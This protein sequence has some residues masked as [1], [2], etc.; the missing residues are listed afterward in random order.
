MEKNNKIRKIGIGI[1]TLLWTLLICFSWFSPRKADSESE[2]RPLAQFPTLNISTVISSKFMTEFEDFS[3]DQFPLR[4][5]FRQMKSLFSSYILNQQDNNGI[6]ISQ[7]Y[8][9]K[10]E[11]PL[12]MDSINYASN[13]FEGI[14]E[15]LLKDRVGEIYTCIVPDKG[16]YLAEES[17]HLS[18][19][20]ETLFD[21]FE[22]LMPY[23]KFIDITDT[24]DITSYYKTDTHWRQEKIID[25]AKKIASAMGVEL[26][27][28]EDY[29]KVKLDRPFYGVYYG[30]AALPMDPEE[31]YILESE[32]ISDCVVTNYETE[33]T[34]AVYDM[35]KLTAKDQYEVFLSGPVSLLSVANPNAESDKELI[36]FRDSFGSAITPLLLQGYKTVTLIDIRYLASNNLGNFVDFHGQDVLFLYSTLVLNNSTTLK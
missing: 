33:K 21:K 19:D 3:L 31:M 18:M 11:Y 24:L 15:K 6:Y 16:Y 9:A 2:R 28:E 25:T 14:Y 5:T 13:K 7:G 34:S 32:L 35:N 10:M 1:F 29:N 8:A 26:P 12:N 20:Y 36:I 17:G 23:S 27:K 22:E 30:Q 4:D